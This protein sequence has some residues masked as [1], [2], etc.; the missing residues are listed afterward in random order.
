MAS[1]LSSAHLLSIYLF[2]HLIIYPSIHFL[3]MTGTKYQGRSPKKNHLRN[4]MKINLQSTIGAPAPPCFTAAM[5][6]IS[7]ISARSKQI[8]RGEFL[9]DE[10]HLIPFPSGMSMDVMQQCRV[11]VSRGRRGLMDFSGRNLVE[12]HGLR[13]KKQH[14]APRPGLKSPTL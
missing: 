6:D 9:L 2:I 5:T 14:L 10:S 4:P 7:V 3:N 11:M 12:F 13:G 1:H 8:L